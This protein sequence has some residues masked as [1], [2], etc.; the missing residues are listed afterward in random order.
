MHVLRSWT[1]QE[2]ACP[3]FTGYLT[4]RNTQQ[5]SLCTL[6]ELST[7]AS[8]HTTELI[9]HLMARHDRELDIHLMGVSAWASPKPSTYDI[10]RETPGMPPPSSS[11]ASVLKD[12]PF[13]LQLPS[14]ADCTLK[15]FPHLRSDV[16][17]L[18]L[19]V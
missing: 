6:Q 7:P 11:L 17:R 14:Q 4:T 8:S 1:W 13:F 10:D 3:V 5:V 9:S 15:T 18:R 19:W 16:S 12:R 2:R